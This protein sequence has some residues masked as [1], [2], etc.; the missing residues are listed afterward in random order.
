MTHALSRARS[1]YQRDGLAGVARAIKSKVSEPAATSRGLAY[2]EKVASS[3]LPRWRMIE[4]ELPDPCHT[5]LDIGS[6]LG[7]M[8]AQCANRGIWSL[9]V[10]VSP[11][12]VEHANDLYAGQP[13]CG[14]MVGEFDP[15]EVS[16][17]P[18]FDLVLALSVSH[19]WYHAYG[20]EAELAMLRGLAQK[21]SVMVFEGP[22]RQER[23]GPK[24]PMFT[25]NDEASV[26]HYY[27]ERLAQ[28]CEGIDKHYVLLGR[29]AGVGQREPFRWLYAI[30]DG[31]QH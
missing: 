23:Y 19:N 31:A 29:S 22:S 24:P 27:A 16:L 26:T 2:Q 9:G 11:K 5:A 14:F 20:A 4:R 17:L 13:G 21:S 1:V 12:L 30:H 7:F 3:N 10:E 8:T 6:N 15:A 25:D 18:R 28:V